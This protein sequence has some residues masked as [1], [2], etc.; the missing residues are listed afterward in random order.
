MWRNQR[1]K[2]KQFE[3]TRLYTAPDRS[4]A[5]Y[6]LETFMKNYTEKLH[7]HHAPGYVTRGKVRVVNRSST[8]KAEPRPGFFP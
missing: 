1:F 5:S 7:S 2:V 8:A 6:W 4:H 3:M